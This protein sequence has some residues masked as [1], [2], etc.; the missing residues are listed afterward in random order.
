M[1]KAVEKVI[2]KGTGA[3]RVIDFE[4]VQPV[5]GGNGEVLRVELGGA[6][7]QFVIVKRVTTPARTKRKK[8]SQDPSMARTIASYDNELAFYQDYAEQLAPAIRLPRFYSGSRLEDGWVFV[9]EDLVDSGFSTARKIYSQTDIQGA[10]KW[11]A[12]FHSSFLGHSGDRLWKAG[13]YWNLASRED[14]RAKMGDSRLKAAAASLDRALNQCKFKTLIHGDAKTDNFC[15]PNSENQ[16]VAGLDFQFVGLGCGMKDVI[17]LLDSCLNLF[18][19]GVEGERYLDFYFREF[20]SAL[21]LRNVNLDAA[22]VEQEWRALYPVAW[23]DYYRFLDGWAPG[24]YPL[25]G[26]AENMFAQAVAYLA[27]RARI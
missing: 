3:T 17:C 18:E 2:R 1:N 11:L 20:T 22:A 27:S 4:S 14:E 13:S 10:L 16:T 26:G 7:V 8:K 19:V 9:L 21:K 5:W 24:K 23:A 6:P 25:E 12:G 15:F